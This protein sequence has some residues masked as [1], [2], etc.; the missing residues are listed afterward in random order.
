MGDTVSCTE[1]QYLLCMSVRS[2]GQTFLP[3]AGGRPLIWL[4][5]TRFVPGVVTPDQHCNLNLPPGVVS[6]NALV[7]RT[8]RPAREA[9]VLGRNIEYARPD[10]LIVGTAEEIVS[11]QT[12]VGI[13]QDSELRYVSPYRAGGTPDVWTGQTDFDRVGTVESTCNDWTGAS[14]AGVTG[15]YDVHR[16]AHWGELD[17]A[18]GAATRSV[19]CADPAGAYLYCVENLF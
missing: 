4:S 11:F 14:G 18:T 10:G 2:Y 8:D 15:R 12:R 9:L 17:T 1:P 7:S 6:A 3:D 13:W 5:A 16:R 19:S